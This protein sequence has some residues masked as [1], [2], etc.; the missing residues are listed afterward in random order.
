MNTRG[1]K[2][3]IKEERGFSLIEALLAMGI[4]LVVL[5]GVFGVFRSMVDLNF[6]ATQVAENTRSLQTVLNL[7]KT[8][9]Q[10]VQNDG[11]IPAAAGTVW[12]NTRCFTAA[13]GSITNPPCAIPAGTILPAG[14]VVNTAAG[15]VIRFDAVKPGMQNGFDAVSIF[16][17][18]GLNNNINVTVQNNGGNIRL[19][20]DDITTANNAIKNEVNPAVAVA[21]NTN[22]FRNIIAGDFIL[23]NRNNMVQLVT[24]TTAAPNP[25]ITFNQV[26]IGTGINLNFNAAAAALNGAVTANFPAVVT[27]MRR[28]T[29]YHET[30]TAGTRWLMRQINA[31]PAVRIIPGTLNLSYDVAGAGPGLN[32]NQSANTV[33][34][35]NDQRNIRMV[36]ITI[37]IAAETPR[38]GKK[39]VSNSNKISTQVAIRIT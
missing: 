12:R 34:N 19:S 5:A 17:E 33:N 13:T 39:P 20:P 18:D 8:D 11:A 1:K 23:F 15:A 3:T 27:R 24:G 4:T 10:K 9:L 22:M 37:N 21:G 31:R 32:Q 2:T 36:R 25:T 30:D 7:I 38:P 14:T 6:A 28:V 26:G 35:N 29:Y 16:Y